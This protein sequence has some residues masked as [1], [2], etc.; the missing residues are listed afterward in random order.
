M[1]N[2]RNVLWGI[3]LIVAGVIWGLNAIGI[4]NVKLFFDGWWTLFIIVPCFL[5]LFKEE[6][7]T[8]NIIGIIIGVA[9]LLASQNVIEFEFVWKMIVPVILV[10]IGASMI[11]KDMFGNKINSEIEKVSKIQGNKDRYSAIFSG[12]NVKFDNQEFLGTNLTSAFGGLECDLR[13]AIITKDVVINAN[14]IFGGID[15]FVPSNVKVKIKSTPIFGGVSDETATEANE[16][17]HTV[18]INGFALFGGIEVK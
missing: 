4:I 16:D 14:A 15:I 1:K 18:Y 10:L 2:F 9:L 7:K 11:L 6:D 13:K 8:G 12:Q 5:D 17:S 3:A